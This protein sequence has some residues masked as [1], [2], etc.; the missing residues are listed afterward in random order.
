MS[1]NSYKGIAKKKFNR[2][3]SRVAVLCFRSHLLVFS[4]S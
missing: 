2:S 4:F 3:L 1:V